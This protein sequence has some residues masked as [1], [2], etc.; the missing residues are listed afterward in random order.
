MR[1]LVLGATAGVGVAMGTLAS[2]YAGAHTTGSK[3][4][5]ANKYRSR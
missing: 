4:A 5:K 3:T 1:V 2:V